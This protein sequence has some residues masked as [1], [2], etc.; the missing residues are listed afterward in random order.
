V[1]LKAVRRFDG[2]R[3]PVSYSDGAEFAGDTMT[4]SLGVPENVA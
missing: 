3:I 4:T 2:L 1:R